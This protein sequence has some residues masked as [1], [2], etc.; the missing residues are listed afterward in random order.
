[1]KSTPVAVTERMPLASMSNLT[2]TCG[3]PRGAGGM[4]SNRKLPRDLLSRTNSRS[5]AQKP[6]RCQC[7]AIHLLIRDAQLARHIE[8]VFI[9]VTGQPGAALEG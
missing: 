2:S 1:M 3:T 8:M 9:R 5:P 6:H 7:T 4:P